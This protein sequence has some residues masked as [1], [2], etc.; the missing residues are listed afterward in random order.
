MTL[1]IFDTTR[2]LGFSALIGMRGV[3]YQAAAVG[4][5]GWFIFCVVSIIAVFAF[6]SPFLFHLS[7]GLS[8][9]VGSSALPCV[10]LAAVSV[11]ACFPFSTQNRI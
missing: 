10:C 8:A 11:T 5:A 4:L 3:L 2:L 6:L 7:G 1:G 9:S